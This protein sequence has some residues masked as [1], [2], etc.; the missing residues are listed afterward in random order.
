[1][2]VPCVNCRQKFQSEDGKFFEKIFLCPRCYSVAT[3]ILERGEARLKWLLSVLRQAI[4]QAALEGRLQFSTAEEAN[5][6][7]AESQQTFLSQLHKLATRVRHHG[8]G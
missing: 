3:R 5:N 6:E 4:K 7:D 2:E 1:M 8:T